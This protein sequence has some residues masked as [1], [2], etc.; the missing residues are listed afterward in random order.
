MAVPD[1]RLSPSLELDRNGISIM[2]NGGLDL[3]NLPTVG[4][5]LWQFISIKKLE[6]PREDHKIES[7]PRDPKIESPRDLKTKG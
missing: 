3:V 5:Y 1:I 6:S 7:P 4:P 2:K